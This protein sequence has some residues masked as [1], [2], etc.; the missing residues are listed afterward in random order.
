MKNTKISTHFAIAIVRPVK[1]CSDPR[2]TYASPTVVAVRTINAKKVPT[3]DR[4]FASMSTSR[5]A[6]HADHVQ[7]RQQEDPDD[8]DE[9]PVQP[10]R[11]DRCVVRGIVAFAPRQYAED[12]QQRDADDQVEG[13]DERHDVVEDEKELNMLGAQ[14]A[15]D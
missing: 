11:L 3:Y 1:A 2:S 8:I 10:H 6:A 15:G 9:V 7:H 12:R 13:V 5:H 4:G 14:I